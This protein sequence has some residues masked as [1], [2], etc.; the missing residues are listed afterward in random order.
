MPNSSRMRRSWVGDVNYGK[1]ETQ[2]TEYSG[3]LFLLFLVSKLRGISFSRDQIPRTRAP[4]LAT[5]RSSTVRSQQHY[6]FELFCSQVKLETAR[7]WNICQTSTYF[8]V[9]SGDWTRFMSRILRKSNN[10]TRNYFKHILGKSKY[11]LIEKN[12]ALGL[13]CTDPSLTFKTLGTFSSTDLMQIWRRLISINWISSTKEMNFITRKS[14]SKLVTTA[15]FQSCW[16]NTRG[17]V[18][19]WKTR[20]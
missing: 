1:S 2:I 15:K 12:V 17:M 10:K 6:N 13:E 7:T 19:I 11:A 5:N 16:P 8:Q 18:D 4:W 3:T 20:K 14:M 9:Q